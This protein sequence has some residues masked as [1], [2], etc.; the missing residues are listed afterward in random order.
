MLEAIVAII[1]SLLS[2]GGIIFYVIK[3]YIDKNQSKNVTEIK[4]HIDSIKETTSHFVGQI[5]NSNRKEALI[6]KWLGAIALKYEAQHAW[7]GLFHNGTIMSN[8]DH[9]LKI[10]VPY[11]WPQDITNK[12]GE[13]LSVRQTIVEVPLSTMGDY[14][15]KLTNDE[16]HH[17]VKNTVDNPVMSY[18]F[19]RWGLVENVNVMLYYDGSPVAVMGLNWIDNKGKT[20]MERTGTHSSVE[21]VRALRSIQDGLVYILMNE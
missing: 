7:V 14:K 18:E 21:A 11:E 15:Q 17:V 13:L 1:G 3:S 8:N 4:N 20:I 9:L 10:T 6:N 5:I 2:S 12:K 19:D 16:W